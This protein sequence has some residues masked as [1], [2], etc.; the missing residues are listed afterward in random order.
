MSSTKIFRFEPS[1]L[2]LIRLI[3]ALQVICGHCINNLGI[4][5]SSVVYKTVYY[6]RGVPIFF[7]ISGCL[8]WYSI[9]RS[10]NY[11]SYLKKRFWRVYPELWCGILIEI[12]CIVIM[13]HGYKIGE[14][15]AFVFTQSTIFQFWTPESLRD[16]GCGTPN[17]ALWTIC[18]LIQFYLLAWL[19]YKLLHNKSCKIWIP[20]IVSLTAVSLLADIILP[21]AA[22]LMI[23]KLY[24]QTVIPYLWLFVVGMCI[25]RF[26]DTLLPIIKH[27]WWAFIII[28]AAA[29]FSGID[30]SAHYTVFGN[31]LM[32]VGMIG[33]AYSFPKLELKTDI[34]Y[35][36]FIYHMTVIN[37]L[38]T[39]GLTRKAWLVPLVIAVSCLLAFVSTTVIGKWSNKMKQRSISNESLVQK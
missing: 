32:A 19:I 18:S 3:A 38:I 8:I 4:H 24:S 27:Y 1:C 34:S 5:V 35:G 30:I 7:V 26:K 39:F 36:L 25:A 29:H 21:K 31:G 2:R 11:V 22:P 12:V 33:F 16:Y 15:T 23:R 9:E 13:Y 28:S 20:S 14:L 17:G 37:V 10:P 6:F